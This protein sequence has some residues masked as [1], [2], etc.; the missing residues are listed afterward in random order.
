MAP[1]RRLRRPLLAVA[2]V[3]V[4]VFMVPSCAKKG[5]PRATVGGTLGFD[6]GRAT[7]ANGPIP[8]AQPSFSCGSDTKEFGAELIDTPP[9]QAKVIKEWGDI[10]IGKQMFVAGVI[11]KIEF[12]MGDLTFTH[13]FDKDFTFDVLPDAPYRALAQVV[14]AGAAEGGPEGTIHMEIEQGLI[15]HTDTASINDYQQGF[16]PSV[17]DRVSVFGHWIVDCGH[18][19]YHT[20]IHPVVFMAFAHTEG[21][22]T[23]VHVYYNPYD[24]TQVFTPDPALAN[25]VTNTARLK[26]PN[27]KTFPSYLVATLKRVGHL[28]A[29]PFCCL[30]RIEAHMMEG[31]NTKEPL[32]WFVCAPGG[33]SG[34]ALN[35]SYHF[36]V[37]P[38]V[39]VSTTTN[40]DTGCVRFQTSLGKAYTPVDPVRKD[41]VDPWDELTAQAEA[42]TGNTN[43]DIKKLIEEQVPPSFVPAVERD[44]VVD[45]Y[46][47][48]TGPPVTPESGGRQVTTSTDQAFPFYG[49]V[50]VSGSPGS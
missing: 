20:E 22:T 9:D 2:G 32:P 28:G 1:P 15:P 43:L 45:C 16:I 27:S 33:A 40:K 26:D 12:S 34:G 5:I 25:Q 35:V 23:L 50:K 19:D 31:A 17:G 10:V 6:Q 29:P 21:S 11:K 46:D 42:A 41:C 39:G 8:K 13:P 24:E 30:D 3:I 48:L 36:S 37:R 49:W 38:G 47:P 7:A 18:N 14:G 44:P 4:L